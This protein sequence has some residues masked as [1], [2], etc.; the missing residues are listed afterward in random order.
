MLQIGAV[1]PDGDLLRY[2]TIFVA[3][4]RFDVAQEILALDVVAFTLLGKI[5]GED[6]PQ[7]GLVVG[8]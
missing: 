4:V 7:M 1:G 2:L 3:K 6:E 8:R 5:G